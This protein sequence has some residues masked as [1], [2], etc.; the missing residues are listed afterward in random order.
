MYITS[1]LICAGKKKARPSTSTSSITTTI[2]TSNAAAA[3][4]SSYDDSGD[5]DDD[6][7]NRLFVRPSRAAKT[8][9]SSGQYSKCIR[10][11]SLLPPLR[12]YLYFLL[13]HLLYIYTDAYT[14]NSAEDTGNDSNDDSNDNNEHDNDDSGS[15][16]TNDKLARATGK[17]NC[18]ISSAA[19]GSGTHSKVNNTIRS[20]NIYTLYVR[21]KLACA[22]QRH[23]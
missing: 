3:M 2:A 8:N 21:L 16:S 19:S 5:V 14:G 23:A 1:R 15:G 20:Q 4:S 12:L 22:V 17:H 11:L 9:L 13:P 10:S 7:T 18:A 6:T